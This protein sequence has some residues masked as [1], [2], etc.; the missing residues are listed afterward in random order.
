MPARARHQLRRA[1]GEA[2]DPSRRERP[3]RLTPIS[4]RL[5]APLRLRALA[6]K[7]TFA[8]QYTVHPKPERAQG[9][10]SASHKLRHAHA[11]RN[12]RLLTRAALVRLLTRA[13]PGV[14]LG[15]RASAGTGHALS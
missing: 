8:P 13:V 6:L 7:S 10:E 4:L 15:P 1:P 3:T 12:P 9:S 5:F 14:S 2:R 11:M